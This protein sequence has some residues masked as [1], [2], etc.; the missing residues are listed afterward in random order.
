[1]QRIV[2]RSSL[3]TA[4][5]QR[6]GCP[7]SSARRCGDGNREAACGSGVPVRLAGLVRSSA[8]RHLFGAGCRVGNAG[9]EG[10]CALLHSVR[11]QS[12]KQLAAE[13]LRSSELVL[14]FTSPVLRCPNQSHPALS[15]KTGTKQS[16]RWHGAGRAPRGRVVLPF[17]SKLSF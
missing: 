6:R 5:G 11:P 3:A 8:G 16:R 14:R 10:F 15:V 4:P 17:E 2:R 7:R 1:V 13:R 12:L 9:V